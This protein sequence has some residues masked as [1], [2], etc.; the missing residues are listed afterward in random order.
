MATMKRGLL[1]GVFAAVATMAALAAPVAAHGDHDARL[2]A[3]ELQ[4]GPYTI[5]LWQVYPDSG[6]SMNP[7]L[8]VLFDGVAAPP[9]A[10]V[11][12]TLNSAPMEV[13]PSFTD[14]NGWETTG[15]IAEGD[16]V[17][18]TIT[19]GNQSWALDPVV[20]PA[21]PT[22]VLPMR[23]LIYVSIFLTLGTA[24][25]VAGRTARAWRRPAVTPTEATRPI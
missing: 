22:S 20:V 18:V 2:L 6:D 10:E 13:Q 19:D 16:M 9:G 12:V 8:I 7:H 23:E 25:W 4:A 21:A 1:L 17:A 24:W 15:G 14:A 11:I 3:R 5:S